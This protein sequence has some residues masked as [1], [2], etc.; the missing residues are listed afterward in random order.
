M[1]DA[2]LDTTRGRMSDDGVAVVI[3]TQLTV[4]TPKDAAPGQVE[5]Q[6]GAL[7]GQAYVFHLE[8]LS[9]GSSTYR[10]LQTLD[11]P[12]GAF[13]WLHVISCSALGFYRPRLLVI[14]PQPAGSPETL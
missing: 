6:L 1:P 12:K 10:Q 8:E 11:A 14:A 3:T 4:N 2:Q 9:T 13:S 5:A 7:P